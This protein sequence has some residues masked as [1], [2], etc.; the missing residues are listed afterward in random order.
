MAILF[1]NFRYKFFE[2]IPL[3]LLFIISFNGISVI[4]LNFFS[5]NVHYILIYFWVLRKPQ[6]LG[7]GFIFLSGVITDVVF[8]LPLGASALA[9][10]VISLVA[11]YVR[12]VTVRITLIND[13]I[14]FIPALLLANFVYFI[15]LYFSNY[16]VDYLYLFYNSIF[17]FIFYPI[18]WGVF[19]LLLNFLKN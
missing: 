17:T 2:L 7:N 12:V 18:L 10:L 1:S 14:S 8:G 6:V 19:T 3:V 13:W 16:S 4:D 11:A 5:L 15:A 9:L